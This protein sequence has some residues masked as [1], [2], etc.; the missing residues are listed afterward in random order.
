[1]KLIETHAH[2]YSE[3]FENDVAEC[4]KRAKGAG[5]ERIYMP[6]VDSQSIGRMLNMEEQYPN[7]CVPM[8]GVHPCSI[9]EDYK[10]ELAIAEEWFSKRDFVAV[11]E[12]GMDLYWDKTFKAQQ[13][14]AFRIQCQWAIEK[15]IPIIIHS[16]ESTLEV[17]GI[18]ESIANEKLRGIFHCFSGSVEEANRIIDLGFYIGIGGVVTYKNGGLDKVVPHIPLEKIVLETD[19]P[20][21]PPVPHRGKRNEVS[22]INLVAEKIGDLHHL[23]VGKIAEITTANAE[24]IFQVD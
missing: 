13:E 18:I 21:L 14:D 4:I 7:Y 22:F 10:K 15:D 12:I 1:M 24:K 16:R 6:N 20:Y 5:V 23:P 11:G 3:K 17:L 19:C 9:A 8:M 2:I